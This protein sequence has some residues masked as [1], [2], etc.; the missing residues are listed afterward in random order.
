MSYIKTVYQGEK[1]KEIYST[2]WNYLGKVAEIGSC[3]YGYPSEEITKSTMK[4]ALN[5]PFESGILIFEATHQAMVNLTNDIICRILQGYA[6][7]MFYE[8][9]VIDG[10]Y[11]KKIA[12][13]ANLL[14]LYE[15]FFVKPNVSTNLTTS[16]TLLKQDAFILSRNNKM[17]LL[18]LNNTSIERRGI[19]K[20]A[21]QTYSITVKP[22]AQY[23]QIIK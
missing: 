4:A 16:G 11:R 9:A 20:F 12:D 23:C 22:Y 8:N 21:N 6:G 2:D 3:G 13:A 15:E 5:T 7:V 19:I 18:Y 17:L 14:S 1:N 10:F